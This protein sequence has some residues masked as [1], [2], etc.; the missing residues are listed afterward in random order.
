MAEVDATV[1]AFIWNYVLPWILVI[2]ILNYIN[3]YIYSPYKA[4]YAWLLNRLGFHMAKKAYRKKERL[5]SSLA[6][7]HVDGRPLDILEIGVGGGTNFEYYPPGSNL[8]CIDPNPHFEK[9]LKDN[10]SKYPHVNLKGFVVGTAEKLHGFHDNSADAIVCTFVLCSVE[11]IEEVLKE[12]KRVLRPG[13][14]FY[15]L[16]HVLADKKTHPWVYKMQNFIRPVWKWV[17]DGCEFQDTAL[18]IE[19]AGFSLVDQEHFNSAIKF[20]LIQPMLMGT[21]TK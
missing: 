8:I 11:D 9:Y 7:L 17:G 3:S 15:F 18:H 10:H 4:A 12:I 21:A 16:E 20:K 13:G 2:I 5:F 1:S 6:K 14:K 19:K